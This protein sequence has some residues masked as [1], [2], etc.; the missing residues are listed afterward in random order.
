MG[1]RRERRAAMRAALNRRPIE[2]E[3]RRRRLERHRQAGEPRPRRPQRERLRHVGVLNGPAVP[4]EAAP[5]CSA[6]PSNPSSI[7]RG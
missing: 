5:D 7:S 1:Q 3:A 6:D 2:H 4:R